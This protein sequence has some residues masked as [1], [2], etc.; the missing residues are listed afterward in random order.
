MIYNIKQNEFLKKR[1][2]FCQFRFGRWDQPSQLKCSRFIRSHAGK[3]SDY[4]RYYFKLTDLLSIGNSKP[5]EQEGT[6]QLRKHRSIVLC[7]KR[8]LT[9][10]NGWRAHGCSSKLE[11]KLWEGKSSCFS[12]TN[13]TGKRR[14]AK[15]TWKIEKYIL[16]SFLP[17][18]TQKN[19]NWQ[20]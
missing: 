14:F 17:L 7:W 3:T 13:F 11:G 2:N 15:Y 6:Y 10:Q 9:T 18:D 1:T 19:I 8:L 12:R 16:I 4:W 20:I 5:I